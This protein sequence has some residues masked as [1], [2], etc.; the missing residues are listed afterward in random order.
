MG[1]RTRGR[2]IISNGVDKKM[3]KE[4]GK[5][6]HTHMQKD[7]NIWLVTA[8]LGFG[9]LDDIFN[10]FPKRA[11]NTGAAEA[12][13]MGI[14]V[15]LAMQGKIPVFY[16]IT[17]FALWRPAETIRLYV[18]GEQIPVKIVGVGRDKDYAHDGP[19]HDATDAKELLKCW[20][21]IQQYW[22]DRVEY[23]DEVV[24]YMLYND[25]PSFLS[26]RRN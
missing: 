16:S 2:K 17:P 10:D 15:G 18:N 5:A 1:G 25:K 21:N 19:S 20:P 3:K 12:A 4:F 24:K 7:E 8:D 26:L 11:I 9:A 6:L 23:I 14:A 13:A 22:P